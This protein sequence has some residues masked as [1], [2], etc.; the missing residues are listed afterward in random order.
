MMRGTLAAV[1]TS[2]IQDWSSGTSVLILQIG[3]HKWRI[4]IRRSGLAES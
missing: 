1:H 3:T 4:L 2:H